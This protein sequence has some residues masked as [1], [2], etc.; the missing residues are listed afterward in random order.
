MRVLSSQFHRR[1]AGNDQGAIIRMR[2]YV[3]PVI[4]LLIC[5]IWAMPE[6]NCSAQ[7][8]DQAGS[9]SALESAILSEMNI[10]RS[11]PGKYASYVKDVRSRYR[12]DFIYFSRTRIKHKEGVTAVD[13]AIRYLV[14]QGPAPALKL[15]KGLSGGAAEQVR[16]QGP[17]GRTGHEGPD[18]SDPWDRV[19]RHGAWKG[20]M[21][22][23]IYYGSGL[24]AREI[25]M[26]FIIDDG[27]PDRSHRDNVF[28]PQFRLAGVAC[29]RHVLYKSMCVVTFAAGF[30]EK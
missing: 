15:S 8:E 23:N 11:G 13:E 6:G 12:G 17:T 22:E 2:M 29:G 30:D 4:F 27:V 18:G 21:G 14:S 24:N 26:G 19:N 28:N 9:L 1:Q 10:A 25:V 5:L 16:M 7:D 20:T 3:R